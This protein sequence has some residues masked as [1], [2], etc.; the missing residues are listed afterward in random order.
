LLNGSSTCR[1]AWPPRPT[2]PAARLATDLAGE[3]THRLAQLGWMF[4]SEWTV[5]LHQHA[6]HP[7]QRVSPRPQQHATCSFFERTEVRREAPAGFLERNLEQ[8]L[9]RPTVRRARQGL[10]HVRRGVEV[11]RSGEAIL[12]RL[13]GQHPIQPEHAHVLAQMA[14][15]DDVPPTAV[16]DDAV[17]ID[18]PLGQI[19]TALVA[20]PDPAVVLRRGAQRQQRRR[21][22]ESGETTQGRKRQGA[23]DCLDPAAQS[24]RQHAVDLG[25]GAFDSRRCLAEADP[26]RDEQTQNQGQR[27]LFGKH[28]RRQL[29]AGPQTVAAVSAGLGFDRYAELLERADVAPHRA[30]IHIQ[31]LCQLA[32]AEA[33]PGLQ[34]FQDG[35][36]AGG[37]MV[38]GS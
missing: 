9:D 3:L 2:R 32:A 15:A 26:A 30:P 7:V 38:H 28:H 37:R 17:G 33:R 35:Q 25:Q 16:V 13:E 10:H 27:F 29:V 4:D 22:G 1:T 31:T 5:K 20:D 19:L 34:Q 24:I 12:E 6:G 18:R 36:H 8:H 11:E 14:P 21:V 23:L